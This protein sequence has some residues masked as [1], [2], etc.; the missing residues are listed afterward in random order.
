MPSSLYIEFTNTSKELCMMK[1]SIKTFILFIYYVSAI[2]CSL[3]QKP[4]L[5]YWSNTRL[6][7][8]KQL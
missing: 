7:E 3:L 6:N 8:R 1:I 2:Y 4:I 5:S